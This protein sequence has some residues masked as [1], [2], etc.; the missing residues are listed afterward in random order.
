MTNQSSIKLRT[1]LLQLPAVL[2]GSPPRP[3]WSRPGNG[4]QI[5]GRLESVA[6][7]HGYG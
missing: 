5:T 6:V 2:K 7:E 4:V 1:D 3:P